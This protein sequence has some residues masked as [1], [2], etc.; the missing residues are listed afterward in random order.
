MNTCGRALMFPIYARKWP[1]ICIY[2]AT[3]IT[4]LSVSILKMLVELLVPGVR[5]RLAS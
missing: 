3:T 1:T 5:P 4:F 2:L